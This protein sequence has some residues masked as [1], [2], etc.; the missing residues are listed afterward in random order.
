MPPMAGSLPEQMWI[1]H[2]EIPLECGPH[3]RPIRSKPFREKPFAL[4]SYSRL[5]YMTHGLNIPRDMAS[6]HMPFGRQ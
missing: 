6:W 1:D 3:N 2:L 4:M 5:I